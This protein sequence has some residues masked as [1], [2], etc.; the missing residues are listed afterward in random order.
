[1]EN[2]VHSS[3]SDLPRCARAVRVRRFIVRNERQRA[4][5]ARVAPSGVG[6]RGRE[7][8]GEHASLAHNDQQHPLRAAPI[9]GLWSIALVGLDLT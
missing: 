4:A 2:E 9:N 7:N 3:P 5:Q 6:R 8:T 1:M